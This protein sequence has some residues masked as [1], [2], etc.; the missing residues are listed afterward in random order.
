MLCDRVGSPEAGKEAS[1]LAV[2]IARATELLQVF[3]RADWQSAAKE[4]SFTKPRAAFATLASDA[5][6]V[7][8][9]T[10]ADKADD[11]QCLLTSAKNFVKKNYLFEKT[12]KDH[13]RVMELAPVALNFRAQCERLVEVEWAPELALLFHRV[14]LYTQ[15]EGEKDD[16]DE[17]V[18]DPVT[19]TGAVRKL[20]GNGLARALG[21]QSDLNADA[22]ASAEDGVAA[23]EF[24]IDCWF[25]I[26][27]QRASE[28][29]WEAA[30]ERA[31]PDPK[32]ADDD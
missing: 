32:D 22:A 1:K 8:K 3:A 26:T 9:K 27:S 30:S 20:F 11:F 13:Y 5:A 23:G 12:R 15:L 14:D 10:V 17:R 7:G 16:E 31:A 6:V 25:N 2:Q 4:S 19:L 18:K 28:T 29:L 24:A 21:R